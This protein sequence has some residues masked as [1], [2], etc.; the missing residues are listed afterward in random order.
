MPNIDFSE[1]VECPNLAKLKYT[2]HACFVCVSNFRF[3]L[4]FV[5]NSSGIF[6]SQAQKKA[7]IPYSLTI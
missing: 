4:A 5:L 3:R 2:I 6:V 1:K 7:L